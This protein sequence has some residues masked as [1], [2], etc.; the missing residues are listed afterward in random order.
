M[1]LHLAI[2]LVPSARHVVTT[3]G[4]PSGM[5]ATASATAICRANIHDEASRQGQTQSNGF[6]PTNTCPA[7]A[8]GISTEARYQGPLPQ[9]LRASAFGDESYRS[10]CQDRANNR[11]EGARSGP[12][13]KS[14]SRTLTR[15]PLTRVVWRGSEG[16]VQGA[17]TVRDAHLEVVHGAAQDASMRGV[18][19]VA[20]VHNPHQDANHRNDLQPP[21]RNNQRIERVDNH[22]SGLTK[23]RAEEIGA[24]GARRRG[25]APARPGPP[26]CKP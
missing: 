26:P 6:V 18:G 8:F 13:H 10:S 5:A 24:H 14:N 23:R 1:A 2:F 19:E 17:R 25:P 16:A 21:S 20:D 12:A 4:R 3:A 9:Q 7:S 22:E 11:T 15:P